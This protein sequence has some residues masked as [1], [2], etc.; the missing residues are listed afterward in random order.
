MPTPADRIIDA[1]CRQ[2]RVSVNHHHKAGYCDGRLDIY[3]PWIDLS[4]T[5]VTVFDMTARLTL[6]VSCGIGFGTSA[7]PL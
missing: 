7:K 3:N 4:S 1:N 5:T 2:N 6:G